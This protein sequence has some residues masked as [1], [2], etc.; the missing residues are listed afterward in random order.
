MSEPFLGVVL[1]VRLLPVVPALLPAL[2]RGLRAAVLSTVTCAP[3]SVR[4]PGSP[5]A[6]GSPRPAW[7]RWERLRLQRTDARGG[8][9]SFE[10]DVTGAPASALQR[11][12]YPVRH[13]SVK[14]LLTWD[15]AWIS[16]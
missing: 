8:C 2:R 9:D 11:A 15:F 16:K 12:R 5:G 4:P 7:G 14:P 6:W 10:T 13:I 1:V 3:P